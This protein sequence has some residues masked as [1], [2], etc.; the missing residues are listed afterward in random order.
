M[1]PRVRKLARLLLGYSLKLKK[2]QLL[3]IA[4]EIVTLPLINAAF[5][6]AVKM[7]V[8]PYVE[9]ILPEAREFMIKHGS[10]NQLTYVLP[11]AMVEINKIDALLFIWGTQNTRYLSGSDPRRQAL[12]QSARKR[13]MSRFFQRT[14]AGQMTWVGTQFPTQADAQQ[15]GMSLSDYEDFVYKAGHLNS[16][17]PVKHWKKVGKEQMRLKRILDRINKLQV[18]SAGTDLTMVV[19]GRKW[20]SCHGTENFPDG[21]IFTSPHDRTVE[22]R[23]SFSYPSIFQG[24]EVTDVVLEFKKGKVVKEAASRNLKFLR[25]M[26]NVDKGARL[27]GEFAIGTN[28]GIKQFTGNTLFDEK[29]GGTCHLAVG[30]AIPEAGGRNKSALHWDMVCDLKKEGEIIGDGKVIYRNGRFTI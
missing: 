16:T 5:E 18:R 9:V 7:G 3:K 2:G 22:G 15:A 26:L 11:M 14:A 25:E 10:R 28:Y 12:L 29:I 6:E 24:R 4:G 1:D 8:N 20:I 17:D 13:Y 30:A 19:K 27:V 21:E 23:I